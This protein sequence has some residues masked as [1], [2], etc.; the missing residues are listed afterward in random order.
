MIG[1]HL[2][3]YQ[4]HAAGGR[5][6]TNSFG[7]CALGRGPR[8]PVTMKCTSGNFS[9]SIAGE[10]DAAAFAQISGRRPEGSDADDRQLRPP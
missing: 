3:D 4:R 10:R 9:P 2:H 7:P 8:T 5:M 1:E 6:C